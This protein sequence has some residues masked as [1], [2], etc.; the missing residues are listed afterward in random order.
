MWSDCKNCSYQHPLP[1]TSQSTHSLSYRAVPPPTP[2]PPSPQ[3]GERQR[4]RGDDDDGD[5]RGSPP[6]PSQ[7]WSEGGR[8][9][10]ARQGVGPV[11]CH[12][13][14][15]SGFSQAGDCAACENRWYGPSPVWKNYF[16]PPAKML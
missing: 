7:I 2:T 6:L 5:Q 4:W 16:W 10:V 13:F 11:G 12:F 15:S 3:E 9:R 14:S 8:G 1:T